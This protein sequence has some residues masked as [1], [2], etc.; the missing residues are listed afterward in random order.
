[1]TPIYGY[2]A[3]QAVNFLQ[4]FTSRTILCCPWF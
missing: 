1:M 4:K 3:K 2:C